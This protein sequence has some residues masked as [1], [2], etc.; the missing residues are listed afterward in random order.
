MMDDPVMINDSRR[1]VELNA[2]RQ[3]RINE[4]QSC[5]VGGW[6]DEML[7]WS[8]NGS[9][10]VSNNLPIVVEMISNSPNGKMV[11]YP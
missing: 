11:R 4:P 10:L 5:M 9:R 2:R 1:R 3:F 7:V 6:V 8:G